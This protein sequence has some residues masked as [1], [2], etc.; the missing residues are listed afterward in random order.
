[1]KKN[2]FDFRLYILIIAFW[3][4][5]IN[6]SNAQEN[7]CRQQNVNIN[8][9]FQ[10]DFML[11]NSMKI[12]KDTNLSVLSKNK[13]ID[14]NPVQL[15]QI[16]NKDKKKKIIHFWGSWCP[17]TSYGI[18]DILN[19]LPK[20]NNYSTYYISIDFNTENQKKIIRN[21]FDNMGYNNDVYIIVSNDSLYNLELKQSDWVRAFYNNFKPYIQ[22]LDK[23]YSEFSAPYTLV[24]DEINNVL[25]N[26]HLPKQSEIDRNIPKEQILNKYLVQDFERINI[27]LK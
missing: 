4:L 17:T 11:E 19:N 1:M 15:S 27:L 24:L 3:T 10:T 16:L 9:K 18:R 7:K 26:K 6:S 12:L 14:I 22:I 23:T 20:D 21:F 8:P 2:Y 5:I 13:I 25:Y